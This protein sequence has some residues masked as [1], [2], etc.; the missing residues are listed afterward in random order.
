MYENLHGVRSG[1]VEPALCILCVKF[2]F[3]FS[4]PCGVTTMNNSY[5][6][7]AVAATVAFLAGCPS[8]RTKD[9]VE[10]KPTESTMPP[11]DGGATTEM[12]LIDRLKDPNALD[13]EPCLKAR[14]INFDL[15]QTSVKSD[16]QEMLNCHALYLSVHPSA[17]LNL[18]GNA[19]ERGSREYNRGLGERRGNAVND[20]LQAQG[21]KSEQIS[22]ISYGEERP[23][24]NDSNEECWAQNRRVDLVY[25]AK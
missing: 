9:P 10:N 4:E 11:K 8:H 3:L 18:E 7:L 24:C 25:T 12:S 23:T 14:T 6:F 1:R 16:F 13:N 5:K 22:V 20:M 19:D 2:S 21:G 17:R 15:D